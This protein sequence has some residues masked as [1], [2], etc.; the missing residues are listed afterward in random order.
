MTIKKF[1]I[2][3]LLI[4]QTFCT[5]VNG[6]ITMTLQIPPQGVIQKNQ[7]WNMVLVNNGSGAY[8]TVNMTLYNAADNQPVLTAVSNSFNLP[9]GVKQV[10]LND[11]NPIQYNYLSPLI[12]KS[13]NGF[14]SIGQYKACYSITGE[15]ASVYNEDCMP[16]SV[17]PL[18]PPILNIPA[19]KDTIETQYPQF[20]WL[21]P[22]PVN[23]FNSLDYDMLLV[24][25]M[26]GQTPEM[27]VQ[28]NLPVYN[29]GNYTSVINSYPTGNMPLDTSKL[30]AWRVIAKNNNLF[31]AQSD[32]FTFSI[33]KPVLS[34]TD[35]HGKYLVMKNRNEST[36][37]HSLS[38]EAIGLKYYSYD[39]VHKA[40]LSF[41]DESGNVVVSLRQTIAYGENY[42]AFSL[43]EKFKKGEIYHAEISDLQKNVY[44]VYFTI[45]P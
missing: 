1:F 3:I 12:D 6:Q 22:T 5:A 29:I 41:K 43:N 11:L 20:A 25:V 27:A 14:L 31:A 21:P 8:V 15:N 45:Q 19:D 39:K 17:E 26:P 13:L 28:Q 32:V 44:T 33:K 10:T 34:F 40:L 16:F 35:V 7:L 38:E 24:E 36:G 42:L 9:K 23:L 4:Q 30:Y 37:V 18:S 2:L